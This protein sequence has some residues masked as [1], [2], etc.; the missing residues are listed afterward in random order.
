MSTREQFL[1]DTIQTA[2]GKLAELPDGKVNHQKGNIWTYNGP[3]NIR[4]LRSPDSVLLQELIMRAYLEKLI[5]AANQELRAEMKYQKNL[6]AI[7]AEEVY[8]HLTEC[9]KVLISPLVPTPQQYIDNWLHQ[10]YPSH[11]PIPLT[12]DFPTGVPS[13]PYVRSKS[14]IMEVQRMDEGGLVFLY[15]FPL[16]LNGIRWGTKTIYPDFTILNRKTHAIYYWEHFGRMDDPRYLGDFKSKQELYAYNGIFGSQ[17]YQTF[18]FGGKPLTL[19][20]VD[21]VI[22]DIKRRG[23]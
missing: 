20:E 11:N 21:A 1:K 6:P 7:T 16:V 9:R 14:E 8:N 10:P 19:H 23:G 3:K 13:C 17:L 4:I 2:E 18:E 22:A 15:E 12:R 5:R